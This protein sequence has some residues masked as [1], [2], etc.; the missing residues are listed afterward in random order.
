MLTV[1]A[2]PIPASDLNEVPVVASALARLARRQELAVV[3]E[4]GP[5]DSDR[6][7]GAPLT[8]RQY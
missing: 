2:L 6:P 1:V 5:A 3:Y 8:Q 4:R 7:G